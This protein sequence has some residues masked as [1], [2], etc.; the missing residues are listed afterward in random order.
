M[1]RLVTTRDSCS[2]GQCA[3]GSTTDEVD[4]D[5]GNNRVDRGDAVALG[6]P[7]GQGAGDEGDDGYPADCG[8][9]LAFDVALT[10]HEV[11]D[12]EDGADGGQGGVEQ[13]QPAHEVVVEPQCQEGAEGAGDQNQGLLF[14]LGDVRVA[15]TRGVQGV[16]VRGPDVGAQ[17]D[18]GGDC[19]TLGDHHVEDVVLAGEGAAD[20]AEAEHQG[21]ADEEGDDRGDDSGGGGASESC[22]V[23]GGG[24]A[25]DEG[26]DDQADG[27]HD[28]HAVGVSE[29]GGDAAALV[30]GG[31]HRVGAE[32]GDEG[33]GHEADDLDGFDTEVGGG[34]H[35]CAGDQDDR[36]GADSQE[37]AGGDCEH[38]DAHAEPAHLGEG[39]EAG[40]QVAADLSEAALCHEVDA[41]AGLGTDVAEEAGVDR[42]D[43]AADDDCP[44]VAVVVEAVTDLRADAHRG[45][46]ESEAQHNK[47]DGPKGTSALL[48]NCL[49]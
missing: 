5:G 45:G 23:R 33:H 47:T 41:Q 19:Q 38:R 6:E 22:E 1:L 11:V 42:E 24:A 31:E 16:V 26:A 17:D 14:D 3:R 44:Q 27:G 37:L 49:K 13:A 32:Q 12:D 43:R 4:N 46:E 2:L 8:E 7:A 20:C 10:V 28:G 29:H 15:Q 35:Q 30:D 40:G 34:G 21:V 18:E 25:G 36:P 39:D 48:R 9:V